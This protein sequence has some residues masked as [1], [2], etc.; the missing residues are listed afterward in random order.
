MVSDP[1]NARVEFL[2]DIGQ[3]ANEATSIV[4]ELNAEA[5]HAGDDA[6]IRLILDAQT[7]LIELLTE[8]PRDAIA[9]T[10]KG[11]LHSKGLR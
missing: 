5:V 11:N 1:Q 8:R 10:I 3:Q 6:R 7:R 9:Q 2:E 4:G